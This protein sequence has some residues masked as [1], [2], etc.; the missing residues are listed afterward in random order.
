MERKGKMKGIKRI[1]A[2]NYRELNSKNNSLQRLIL[3][4]LST[5]AFRYTLAFISRFLMFEL[6]EH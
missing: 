5:V 6:I 4:K 1:K 2:C 3:L